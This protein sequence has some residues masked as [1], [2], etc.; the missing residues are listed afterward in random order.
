MTYKAELNLLDVIT[1]LE[2]IYLKITELNLT[3]LKFNDKI[4]YEIKLNKLHNK[5]NTLLNVIFLIKNKLLD[6]NKS[7]KSDIKFNFNKYT[8]FDDI[9][10]KKLIMITSKLEDIAP[11]HTSHKSFS[12]LGSIFYQ[13]LN[14][15]SPY[16]PK[17]PMCNIHSEKYLDIHNF[18]L[19]IDY[20]LYKDHIKIYLLKDKKKYISYDINNKY[21]RDAC[22]PLNTFIGMNV[23]DVFDYDFKINDTSC[24]RYLSIYLTYQSIIKGLNVN[25]IVVE[26][27]IY[28]CSFDESKSDYCK[29]IVSDELKSVIP[30]SYN[31]IEIKGNTKYAYYISKLHL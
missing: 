3:D 17:Y 8:F 7:I 15:G 25:S 16:N 12:K 19:D 13:K 10:S 20:E 23:P 5:Q 2:D 27:D 4:S 6:K 9:D 21:S 22:I 24:V 29:Y 30:G 28:D 11:S 1:D 14:T 18:L 26:N 31:K